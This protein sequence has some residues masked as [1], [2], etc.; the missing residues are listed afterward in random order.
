MVFALRIDEFWSM[1]SVVV[2]QRAGSL[3]ASEAAL[4]DVD[5]RKQCLRDQWVQDSMRHPDQAVTPADFGAGTVAEAS[6]EDTAVTDSVDLVEELA[7][8]ED[9][10]ALVD[11]R[12]QMLRLVLGVGV[13]VDS[14]EGDSIVVLLAAT[15]SLCDLAMPTRTVVMIAMV[16][17]TE[18][19][20]AWVTAVEIAIVTGIV[21]V[22]GM[23]AVMVAVMVVAKTMDE[24]EPEKMR[25]AT[26]IPA[27]EDATKILSSPVP[28]LFSFPFRRSSGGGH[29]LFALAQPSS[30]NGK[31]IGREMMQ[32]SDSLL[33]TGYEWVPA[34]KAHVSTSRPC[35]SRSSLRMYVSAIW[36]TYTTG[37]PR[38]VSFIFPSFVPVPRSSLRTF[39]FVSV[40]FS[41]SQWMESSTGVS[42]YSSESNSLEVVG[43]HDS[44]KA[45]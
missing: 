30:I 12:L 20:T 42:M 28:W 18:T 34:H 2:Q 11:R 3:V 35:W 9:A 37:D 6:V 7:T 26:T 17:A 44:G 25:A 45:R 13:V 16:T 27:L 21:G 8:R 5:T 31:G 24:S 1:W 10:M 4:G 23:V 36:N 29:G 43:F 14:E 38:V 15:A 39:H 41:F 22:T 32:M 40:S 19:V 33:T